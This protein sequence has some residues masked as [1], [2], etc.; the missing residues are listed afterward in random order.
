MH[1]HRAFAWQDREAML[2]FVGEISFCTICIDGPFVV[3][4]PVAVDAPDRTRFHVARGNRAAAADGLAPI[5]PTL[6]ALMRAGH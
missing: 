6:A 3:H 4:A 2:A 5:N 1:P